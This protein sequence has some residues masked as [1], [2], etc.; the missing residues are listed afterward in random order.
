MTGNID[1]MDDQQ[2]ALYNAIST[3]I[4][5]PKSTNLYALKENERGVA[6]GGGY[7]GNKETGTSDD[8]MITKE[9][10]EKVSV[11][12]IDVYDMQALDKDKTDGISGVSDLAHE[13]Y[14]AYMYQDQGIHDFNTC[15]DA[16]CKVQAKVDGFQSVANERT[17][18]K[19]GEGT[20]Y[21]TFKTKDG[22]IKTSTL[23]F[24]NNNWSGQSS[25]STVMPAPTNSPPKDIERAP[26]QTITIPCK[27]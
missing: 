26:S 15:H 3:V 17:D 10:G 9:N 12:P 13:I 8:I 6:L 23:P 16:A 19:K 4:K 14:E 20:M 7:T 24:S 25:T 5:S 1:K 2:L 22:A 21:T 18:G 11:Q 27:P